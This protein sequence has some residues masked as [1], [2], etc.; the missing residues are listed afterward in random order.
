[1]FYGFFKL[2]RCIPYRIR[3]FSD[4]PSG[5]AILQKTSK[6]HFCHF[7]M[8]HRLQRPHSIHSFK[9]HTIGGKCGSNVKT[10]C[11]EIRNIPILEPEHLGW[12]EHQWAV[13]IFMVD[14]HRN[15][16]VIDIINICYTVFWSTCLQISWYNKIGE[17]GNNYPSLR[18]LLEIW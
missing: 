5:P 8:L 15:Q 14:V 11:G 13:W 7:L 1:M 2:Q 17:P 6:N 4:K 12:R 10:P 16:C 3:H 9:T 18:Q